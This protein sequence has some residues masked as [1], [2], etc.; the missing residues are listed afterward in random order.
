MGETYTDSTWSKTPWTTMTV[1][2]TIFLI[3]FIGLGPL[4]CAADLIWSDNFN[5]GDFDGWTPKVGLFTAENYMLEPT[6]SLG[7][8]SH[9]STNT[10]GTWSF[11]VKRTDATEMTFVG[12]M[13]TLPVGGI[14][15][16][17]PKTGYGIL[18]QGASYKLV[19]VADF[20]PQHSV[21]ATY[22]V[23]SALDM[24]GW[25]HINVTRSQQGTFNVFING[26]WRMVGTDTS[27]DTS[28][29]FVFISGHGKSALDTVVV[30]DDILTTR[31]TTTDTTGA[32][33]QG[34]FPI[35]LLAIGIGGAV[36]V[37]IIALVFIK[38]K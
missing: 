37:I 25:H 29:V 17:I 24:E 4:P 13:G 15:G 28:D 9:T 8:A 33:S 18:F 36:V 31:I 12:F 23:G 1:V 2:V 16:G 38:R 27:V 34:G 19:E 6:G 20:N 26:T 32:D 11:S 22:S 10:S 21:I 5:D 14:P 3:C 7:A 30:D 35:E